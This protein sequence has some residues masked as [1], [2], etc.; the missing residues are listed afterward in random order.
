M[1]KQEEEALALCK[2]RATQDMEDDWDERALENAH[3]YTATNSNVKGRYWFGIQTAYELLSPVYRS[4]E[5]GAVLEVGVGMG[6]VMQHVAE[7][8]DVSV[9]VDVSGEMLKKAS[10]ILP[11]TRLIKVSGK[12]LEMLEDDAFDLVYCVYVLDHIPKKIWIDSLLKEM[13]R[14]VKPEGFVRIFFALHDKP[15][16]DG[17]SWCG[18]RYTEAEWQECLKRAGFGTT[19]HTLSKR[20]GHASQKLCWTT[21]RKLCL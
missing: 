21:A 2:R 13:H 14:V 8:F 4:M 11:D 6:R 1:N 12:T 19:K 3:F 16:D 7:L 10:K 9:G 17:T 20:T 15:H 18:A 5:K